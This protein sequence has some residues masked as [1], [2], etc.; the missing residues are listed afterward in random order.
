MIAHSF[1]RHGIVIYGAGRRTHQSSCSTPRVELSRPVSFAALCLAGSCFG[2]QAL[3]GCIQGN[4]IQPNA[5]LSYNFQNQTF[6]ASRPYVLSPTASNGCDSPAQTRSGLNGEQ[7]GNG[8]LGTQINS[9]NTAVR[10]FG[11]SPT[12]PQKTVAATI[13][14]TG[15]AGGSGGQAGPSFLTGSTQ[16]G[17]GGV[18]GASEPVTV[19]FDATLLPDSNNN[20]PNI[21][22]VVRSLTGNSGSAGASTSTSTVDTYGGPGGIGSKGG[23]VTVA[24]SGT[25]AVQTT[26]IETYSTGGNG[27]QGGQAY[28]GDTL[29]NIYGGA[30]GS[31]G[32]GG[33]A[34]LAFTSGTVQA[35]QYGLYAHSSGGSGGDGGSTA[36]Q[37]GT[38]G[39]AAGAGGS[40]GQVGIALSDGT[41]AV[42]RPAGGDGLAAAVYAASNGGDGGAGGLPGGALGA[43]GGS[44]GAG[45][46]GG[47]AN[48]AIT[49][50]VKLTGNNQAG[51]ADGVGILVQS[52]GGAGGKGG[53]ESSAVGEGGGGGRAGNGGTAAL[54]VGNAG[55]GGAPGTIATSGNFAHGALVQSVGGGGGVGGQANFGGGGGNGGIGG[56]GGTA[57]VAVPNGSIV[58]LGNNSVG[59]VAQSIGGG[60]GSGGD[61]KGVE[62]VAAFVVGG[63]GGQ[64]GTGGNVRVNLGNA[65]IGSSSLTKSGKLPTPVGGGGV[66]AQSIGGAGGNAGSASATGGGLISIVI[67]GNA[68]T[69]GD[70]GTVD[71]RSG[72]LVTTFGDHAAGIQAQSIG[73][74]GGKGGSVTNFSASP[75]PTAAVS[76]GGQGGSGGAGGAVSVENSSQVATYGTDAIG[77]LMQSI[78]GGGGTGGSA[79]ANAVSLSPS[80]YIP[81]VSITVALGGSGGNGGSGSTVRLNNSGLITTGGDGG[82]GVMA[83]SVGG[84]GGNGGDSSAA[85]YSNG[86]QSAVNISVAVAVGGSG[87]G[88]GSGGA[89]T[90]A[91]SG[92]IATAGQDAYGVFAQSI[93]G[94]GGLGGSGDATATAGD[95]KASFGASVAVGGKG[96]GG[97]GGGAVTLANTGAVLTRGDGSDGVF[98][99]SVGGGGGAAGG[100]TAAASGSKLSIVVGIGGQGGTGGDG[101]PLNVSNGGSVITRGTNARGL[102]VQSIGGGGG[103][104]GKSGATA[105]GT[106]PLSSAQSLFDTVGNGLNLG[107]T[108]TDRG[109][110]IF[111]IGEIG[112]NIQASFKELQG[113]FGQPQ[114]G[115]AEEGSS[116]S[117]QVSVSVGG[118]G[119]LGGKGNTV[120]A[121]N[122]G[123]IST[124]GATSDAIYAQ[125][126]GGGGGSGGAAS[127]TSAASDDGS[128][129]SAIAVGGSG[130]GGGN[131]GTVTVMNALGSTLSTQGVASFGIMAQSVGGGGGEGS[132][133]GTVDGSL[134]SLGV[135][136]GGSG[137]GAG[138]G[139]TV[140]VT[141]NGL[142]TT[143][144]KHGVGILAQSVGGGGGLVRTITTNETFDPSKILNN[145]QGRIADIHGL[146]LNLGGS[147]GA[148]GNGGSVSVV[149]SSNLLTT[150]LDAHGIVAQSIGGGG[151]AVVGGQTTLTTSGNA[152]ARGDGGPVSVT[153]SG[154]MPNSGEQISTSGAGASA[155]IAQSIGGGGGLAGDVSGASL[156]LSGTQ[157]LIKPGTG[158]GGA[159]TI[160]LNGA[161]INTGGVNGSAIIAQSIGGGG[162]MVAAAGAGAAN[163]GSAGSGP[164]TSSG[165]PVTIKLV[166][167]TVEAG[168]SGA[169]GIIANSA[170]D[171]GRNGP[172]SISID[173]ESAVVGSGGSSAAALY[174]VFGANNRIEN[175]GTIIGSRQDPGAGTAVY[176]N[177]TSAGSTTLV[178]T[179][180]IQG[181]IVLPA[182]S[183]SLVENRQGGS[184]DA[185]T[186]DLGASGRLANAG[187]LEIGGRGTV[188]T[189]TVNGDFVQAST[190]TLRVDIDPASGSA[191]RLQVTGR[192][193]LGGTIEGRATSAVRLRPGAARYPLLTATG[194]V[195]RDGSGITVS[196]TPVIRYDI[197]QIDANTIGFDRTVDL[198]GTRSLTERG[199]VSSNRREVGRALNVVFAR[200]PGRLAP[201]GDRLAALPTTAALAATLDALSGEAVADVQQTAF[202]TQSLFNTTLLR[203][204]TDTD[205][206]APVQ[207][208]RTASLTPTPPPNPQGL[209]V[210]VGGFGGS[211]VLDGSDGRGS[212]HTQIA[213][214]LMGLDKWF[215]PDHM[216]G[217]SV[218]GG[219][220]DFSVADRGAHGHGTT[221]QVGGY[222]LATFGK[223]Y[224]SG[225]VSYGNLATTVQRGRV[226]GATDLVAAARASVTSNILG[227]QVELGWRQ[228]A[229]ALTL[230]PFAA[231][232]VNHVWQ[233][234]VN[235]T[236]IGSDAPG[237]GLRYGRTQ[238]TSV[239]LTL[240]GR[241]GTAFD[242]GGGR[243]LAV[244]AELGWVHEFNTQRSVRAAFSAAPTSSFQVLGASAAADSATVGFNGN[245]ALT[246]NVALLGS[247]KGRFAGTETAV[248][249]FGGLQVTW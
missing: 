18:G 244:S 171:N 164:G 200:E 159:V 146:S 56:D 21:G 7:G 79:A 240:G 33:P 66:L 186:I 119:G 201:L 110:G 170:G 62:V 148:N 54:T 196:G 238:R 187:A 101:G 109:D 104:G 71:V 49:G 87:G 176:S 225:V 157:S 208:F 195:T 194:G 122:T 247:F 98:A 55:S 118:S 182:Q 245:L 214:G 193:T 124:Y 9:A 211:D 143:T 45:G 43:G 46:P 1:W 174:L 10:I 129:Q 205:A 28:S 20:L 89:V 161:T 76:I 77:V 125:S 226:G 69:G 183:G 68:G 131:G 212:L 228:P 32:N 154:G 149:H 140:T 136:V 234:P 63:N 30:G 95:A 167:S 235:E 97:G 74:G 75:V 169:S 121:T 132:M 142:I 204:A 229:G 147:N 44:G 178:N 96:G 145:P 38:T 135:G 207:P 166:N 40:G 116:T 6:D 83:Q 237:L 51:T 108:T 42:V 163:L 82:I 134:K 93:G 3:A 213:G 70:G 197:V 192:A 224:V 188:G 221:V 16:G 139:G 209:R 126:V 65:V 222:G 203:H 8:Q 106:T 103:R 52:N 199:L 99:Q 17:A 29:E 150:G 248:G 219:S 162:G 202:A 90:L 23:S 138:D 19:Q 64:G 242:V 230:T 14:T 11:G 12:V 57:N 41:I 137:A 158:N 48:V 22:L 249:G 152:N 24:A 81:A 59:V 246:R 153:L 141:N 217:I 180:T 232:E 179:G 206:L 47:A 100:G 58:T 175:Q 25:Y 168:G 107:K 105:G 123:V 231:L 181:N 61:A 144:G 160:S 86:K 113:I 50:T 39:G 72:G 15:G 243:R 151:G 185:R 114:A 155:I 173:S 189:T 36:K 35:G 215:D 85:S 218:G 184:I 53:N 92:V 13:S 84:G 233:S 130:K 216:V 102:S 165:G 4:N 127:S 27:G 172:I 220:T 60:G 190:G 94:G 73:G 241:V 5:P 115:G 112:E 210:W 223:A 111:Q 239:P 31:G 67:G 91:N 177:V 88:G 128:Y 156:I 78:G 133:A 34:S 117:F 80:K 236:E 37:L 26:G 120:S 198:A 191:D 227:S 2:N